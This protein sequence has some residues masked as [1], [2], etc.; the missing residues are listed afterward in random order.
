M[1]LALP[2]ALDLLVICVEGGLG[3]DQSIARVAEELEYTH[4]EL[5]DEFHLINLEMRVGRSRLEALQELADRT[6]VDDVRVIEGG[7]DVGGAW[8]WNRYPGARV[9]IESQEYSYSF[10]EAL[11]AGRDVNQRMRSFGKDK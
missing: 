8:Y 11:E 5:S 4:P 1:V 10:D 6:G 9:D 2:D 7:G 3:L